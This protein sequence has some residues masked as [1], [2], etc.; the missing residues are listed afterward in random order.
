VIAK[1]K[2]S[3]YISSVL[4]EH[5]RWMVHLFAPLKFTNEN[6]PDESWINPQK[7]STAKRWSFVGICCRILFFSSL[8][9]KAGVVF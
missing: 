9:G 8:V 1:E 2:N 5:L 4:I 3:V 6:H 7:K